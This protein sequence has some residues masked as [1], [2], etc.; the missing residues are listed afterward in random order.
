MSTPTPAP[1]R[2]THATRVA[3]TLL[4]TLAT[5]GGT[6]V[7]AG[8]A[9]GAADMPL[10]TMMKDLPPTRGSWQLDM[11]EGSMRKDEKDPTGGHLKMCMSAA[12]TMSKHHDD[13]KPDDRCS[14]RMLEDSANRAVMESTCK[15]TPPTVSRVTMTRES[16]HSF[17]VEE[18]ETGGADRARHSKI[19]MTYLGPC[20]ASDPVVTLD[21]NS[22]ACREAR[23]HMTEMDP[24]KTC[25]YASG[26]KHAQCVQ[27]MQRMRDQMAASCGT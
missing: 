2:P 12:Q 13:K 18:Q 27:A 26:D 5:V 9:L 14:G 24:E 7:A 15:G 21:K 10:P 22:E 1:A 23:A 25:S 6:L 8:P 17:L 20:G 16:A 4:A 19:R 11:L 3:M